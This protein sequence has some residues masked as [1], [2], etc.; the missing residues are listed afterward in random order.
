MK[1]LPH[2]F[3]ISLPEQLAVKTHAWYDMRHHASGGGFRNP[4]PLRAADDEGP[5]GGTWKFL[6]GQLLG[7]KEQTP[8]PLADMDADE[9]FVPAERGTARVTW[10]GH[11]TVLVQFPT[12][13]LLTDPVWARRVGPFELGGPKRQVPPPLALED[14][15]PIDAVIISHNHY[16]HLDPKALRFLQHQHAP[17][18][19]VP[20]GVDIHMPAGANVAVFDWN[21]FAEVHGVRI[22]CAPARHFSGRTLRDRN[23]TL[24][25]SWFFEPVAKDAPSVY[26]VGDSGYAPHFAEIRERLGAPDLVL[27]PIGAYR[28]RAMMRPVHVNPPEALQAFADL[29]ARNL[30]PIHWGTYDL[31]EEPLNEPPE[32]LVAEAEEL[33]IADQIHVLAAG[34]QTVVCNT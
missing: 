30:V 19:L 28:P 16:D 3:T 24:W 26:Y 2:R 27:M 15:P 7:N 31:A 13:T 8:A 17:S 5:D 29:E 4:W 25:A 33:G 34:G 11:S 14:L 6:M 20:L 23:T 1:P 22:H 12:L 9:L 21:Q 32:A 18:F 10:L